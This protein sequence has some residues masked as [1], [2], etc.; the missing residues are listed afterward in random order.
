MFWHCIYCGTIKD[1]TTSYHVISYIYTCIFITMMLY[2]YI[3]VHAT[4]TTLY[5]Y[6]FNIV[7][8]IHLLC[9]YHTNM[10]YYDVM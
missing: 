1:N 5:I 9:I 7:A 10:I 8:K 3:Y 6:I 4:C 2:I